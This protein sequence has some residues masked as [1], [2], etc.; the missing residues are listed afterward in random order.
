[1]DLKRS[2][3]DDWLNCSDWTNEWKLKVF[4]DCVWALPVGQKLGLCWAVGG[5]HCHLA[6]T[7]RVGLAGCRSVSVL[8]VLPPCVVHDGNYPV[9]SCIL[10]MYSIENGTGVAASPMLPW[11]CLVV[12][13]VSCQRRAWMGWSLWTPV[14]FDG[15]QTGHRA[16]GDSSFSLAH[17]PTTTKERS[18]IN[19]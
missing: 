4:K 3:Q 8:L 9:C 15:P 6:G 16:G 18:Y 13:W 2:S 12:L 14:G 1:M 11:P 10:W 19:L 7:C 5:A 17:L